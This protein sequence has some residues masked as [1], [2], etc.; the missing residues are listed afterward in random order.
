MTLK[1][2]M[3]ERF[4]IPHAEYIMKVTEINQ[5]GFVGYF[6]FPED[7]Q[8]SISLVLLRWENIFHMEKL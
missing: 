5:N 2:T 1:I 4:V 6:K 8:Y 7:E 3:N